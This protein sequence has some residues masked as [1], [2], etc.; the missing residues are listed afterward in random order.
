MLWIADAA[1]SII[2]GFYAEAARGS[3]VWFHR[4]QPRTTTIYRV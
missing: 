4:L 3:H 1:A 2:A